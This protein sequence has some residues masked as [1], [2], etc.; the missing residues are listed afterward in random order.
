METKKSERASAENKR[1]LFAEI[2][3]VMALAAVWGMFSYATPD[4]KVSVLAE[5]TVAVE[6]DDVPVILEEPPVPPQAPAMPVLTE[7]IE[8]VD[9]EIQVE[10]FVS[11]FDDTS[12]PVDFY[13]YIAEQPEE[14]DIKDED[15]PFQIVEEK[16]MFNGGDANEFSRWVNSH[17]VYPE[18]AKENGVQ[19]KVTLQFTVLKDGSVGNIKILRGVDSSLDTEAVRVVSKSPK[20]KPGRQRDRAVNVTYTFPVIF[21]LR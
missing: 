10:D 5:M 15:I 20:W 17:L 6:S 8:I 14:E 4:K 21:Q 2:G 7:E 16:P 11:S 18:L 3:M 12:S 13:D 9:N 19:G 1:F